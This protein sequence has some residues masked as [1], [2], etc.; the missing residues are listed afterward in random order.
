MTNVFIADAPLILRLDSFWCEKAVD[1]SVFIL[2]F[3]SSELGANKPLWP[4][5]I[6]MWY[7][8][9][10]CMRRKRAFLQTAHCSKLNWNE[11]RRLVNNAD[12][13]FANII[14]KWDS[15]GFRLI[16]FMCE[17][18]GQIQ[19]RGDKLKVGA[20]KN[21]RLTNALLDLMEKSTLILG[22]ANIP[23]TTRRKSEF[24]QHTFPENPIYRKQ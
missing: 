15:A 6:K 8:E 14:S 17:R 24:I 1:G 4:A 22:F 16:F 18:F 7:C 20:G 11:S 12:L 21:M 23:S 19:F 10:L 5:L 9:S 13:L 3:G 2:I